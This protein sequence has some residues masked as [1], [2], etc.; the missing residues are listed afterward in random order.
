VVAGALV[1][2]TGYGLIFL[3]VIVAGAL[4]SAAALFIRSVR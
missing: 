1:A 2:S 4:S 3:L